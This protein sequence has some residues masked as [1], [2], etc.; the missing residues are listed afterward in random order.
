MPMASAEEKTPGSTD[1]SHRLWGYGALG[2]SLLTILFSFA[3]ARG[4]LAAFD[5][6]FFRFLD[7]WPSWS[8]QLILQLT[9]ERVESRLVLDS[10]GILVTLS[11]AVLLALLLKRKWHDAFFYSLLVGGGTLLTAVFKLLVQRPRPEGLFHFNLFGLTG[12]VISYS[13]PSGHVTKN[14]L[15]FAF[16]IVLLGSALQSRRLKT[17]IAIFL[18]AVLLFIGIAQILSLRHYLSDMLGGLLLIGS[19]LCCSLWATAHLKKWIRGRSE[20]ELESV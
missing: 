4:H 7:T 12:E 1:D 19:W 10:T 8:H 13:Y 3:T 5:A 14:G 20:H 16:L 17:G 2:G 11:L 15:F 6:A 18:A 9:P